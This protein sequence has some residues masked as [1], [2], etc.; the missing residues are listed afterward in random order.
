M[1]TFSVSCEHMP[2]CSRASHPAG[3]L[4]LANNTL[5]GNTL[6]G[7][8]SPIIFQVP[9]AS[10]VHTVTLPTPSLPASAVTAV[11]AAVA[12][13]ELR[14][15]QQQS[16]QVPVL[17]FVVVSGKRIH[18]MFVIRAAELLSCQVLLSTCC[19]LVLPD[20]PACLWCKST[21]DRVL[22]ALH[23]RAVPFVIRL[24]VETALM[25]NGDLTVCVSWHVRAEPKL[26][27]A[28]SPSVGCQL[29]VLASEK[30]CG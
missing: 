11:G 20:L 5:G 1:C 9:T 7:T 10:T 24:P 2:R 19:R 18:L 21:G 17:S 26:R 27:C 12:K 28:G 23:S 29:H 3:G 22:K 14:Q 8:G 30:R 25:P 15:Q 16:Q 13:Q 4:A 6:T